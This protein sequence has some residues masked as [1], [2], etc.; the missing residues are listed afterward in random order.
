M[1]IEARLYT[2]LTTYPAL[3]ALTGARWSPSQLPQNE[4]LPAGTYLRVSTMPLLAHDAS[5]PAYA[6]ARFQLD[7]WAA[8]YDGMLALRKAVREAMGAWRL[9]A[10]PRVDVALLAGD[11]DTLEAEP[12]RWRCTLDFMISYEED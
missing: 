11:W 3:L 9:P 4:P 10:A 7:G 6:T 8:D 1:S 5:T 2:Q 12:G